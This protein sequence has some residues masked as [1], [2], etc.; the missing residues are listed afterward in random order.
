MMDV[1]VS[2]NLFSYDMQGMIQAFFPMEKFQIHTPEKQIQTLE[3]KEEEKE[4]FSLSFWKDGK[5]IWKES[6]KHPDKNEVK[7]SIYLHLQ[8]MTGI[9]LPWGILTGVKP[10]KLARRM[11]EA[12]AGAEQTVQQ[13]K[14]YYLLSREKAEQITEIGQR[15]LSLVEPLDLKEGVSIYIGIPFCPTICAYCSFSAYPIK[16][17]E[18]QVER[19]LQALKK[20]LTYVAT[21]LKGRK[22]HTVYIG[23]GTPSSLSEEQ[24]EDLLSFVTEILPMDT[25]LEF[26]VEAGRPD[27]ITLGK[28][29]IMRKYGVHRISVNPQTMNQKTLDLLGRKHLVTEIQPVFYQAREL[30]FQNINMDLIVGLP[31]ESVA[32][33]QYSLQEV[34]AMDPDSVTVHT[35]VIKRASHLRKQLLE[36]QEETAYSYNDTVLTMQDRSRDILKKAGYHPYYMYRQKNKALSSFNSNQ[37][38]VA[39]A[40]PGKECL[41][42]ILIMEELETIIAVGS[43]GSTKFYD[44]GKDQIFRVENVKSVKDYVERLD[45]MIDRKRAFLG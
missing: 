24:M 17:Y 31:E 29:K 32:D 13:L 22:I 4:P 12:G 28:L 33:Q 37:E 36:N 19:Y 10:V 16:Q 3:N 30:G 18:D 27:S 1:Y 25:V 11:L 5:E 23:G 26:T 43:G 6:F 39:Y 14:D 9:S 2:K 45:E 38:N 35:L 40:K 15:E 42:N 8:D 41:Y 44:R 34:L 20:E 21:H 7:R